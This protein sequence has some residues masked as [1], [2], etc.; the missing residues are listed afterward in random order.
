MG[1]DLPVISRQTGLRDAQRSLSPGSLGGWL[2]KGHLHEKKHSLLHT[3]DWVEPERGGEETSWALST[4]TETRG[5]RYTLPASDPMTH[6]LTWN[7][8]AHKYTSEP[9]CPTLSLWVIQYARDGAPCHLEMGRGRTFL[10]FH[11]LFIGFRCNKNCFDVSAPVW[12]CHLVRVQ[13][14]PH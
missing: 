1:P 7:T 8:K 5:H 6:E 4:G 12:Q 10:P 11:V 14:L 3:K 9:Y 13:S 2:L